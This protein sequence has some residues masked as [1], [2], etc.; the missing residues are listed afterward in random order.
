MV[1]IPELLTDEFLMLKLRASGVKELVQK[2]TFTKRRTNMGPGE[3]G[4]GFSD[5]TDDVGSGDTGSYGGK[6]NAAE[7]SSQDYG[8]EY[9]SGQSG[10]EQ[11]QLGYGD[12]PTGTY[13]TEAEEDE[14]V[15]PEVPSNSSENESQE[16]SGDIGEKSVCLN[17][18]FEYRR[19]G[20]QWRQVRDGCPVAICSP[21]GMSGVQQTVGLIISV[22]TNSYPGYQFQALP[23]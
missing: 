8:T 6:A 12:E 22:L 17:F 10:S 4:H 13:G 18:C 19:S 9:A 2:H 3:D 11:E 7:D 21:G 1:V 5:Q 16:L 14:P 15:M 20:G 23:T